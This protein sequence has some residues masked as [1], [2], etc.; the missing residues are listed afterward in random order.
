MA[1]RVSKETPIHRY[2]RFP[3]KPLLA[4]THVSMET[5]IHGPNTFPRS[6]P[7]EATPCFHGNN[8][9]QS[10]HLPWKAPLAS[11]SAACKHT[12]IDTIRFHGTAVTAP[13]SP[14]AMVI[15]LREAR[16][17]GRHYLAAA[18]LT[19]PNCA[20]RRR[21][22]DVYPPKKGPCFPLHT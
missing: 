18:V 20:H 3:W 16:V 8:H 6:P 19:V 11:A 13:S 21:P 9:S 22:C 14:F 7:L 2:N 15:P 17:A 10:Q 4:A 1:H 5:A 12:L